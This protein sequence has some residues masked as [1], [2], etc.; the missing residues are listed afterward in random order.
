MADLLRIWLANGCYLLAAAAYTPVLLWQMVVQ[1]KNRHGWL[2]RFGFVPKRYGLQPAIWIH[3]VS[4]G[5]VNATRKFVEQLRTRLPGFQI[6][7]STTTDTGF[8][9]A[10]RLYG[11]QKVFRFP[12]DLS[13]CMRRALN[14]LRP[15][16]IVLVELEV[17]HNLVT[18]ATQMQI[19]VVVVNGRLSEKSFRRYCRVKGLVRGMFERLTLVAA[20]DETYARR[21]EALGVPAERISITGS[22]KFDTATVGQTVEGADSLARL[23]AL[24]DDAKLWVAG[25]T[26]PS[27]EQII[28]EAHRKVLQ[29]I[30]SARLAIVPRKPERFNQVAEIIEKAGF[31]CLRLSVLKEKPAE[32]LGRSQV[33]LGDTM[34]DLRKFYALA[35]VALVG[36]SLVP[37]GGSDVMEAAALAKP[38]IVGPYTENFSEPVK[39][40]LQAEAAVRVSDAES[41]A[42]AVSSFLTDETRCRE[43]GLRAQRIIADHQGASRSTA[44]LVIS[45]LGFDPNHPESTIAPPALK[46]CQQ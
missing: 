2:Q 28:L 35:R 14:R 16:L 21:F 37:M 5:E 11:G 1:K 29:R 22:M 36:R 23:I 17:W 10:C 15:S 19:P 39:L 43:T 34:G 31:Q 7:I 9:R 42:E 18:L 13:P 20:Q 4:V 12:V 45:L 8:E 27:E 41:L 33:I 38:V 25:S 26:G 46:P 30:D 3:A 40:L 44:D 24:Q 6:Y 32:Q